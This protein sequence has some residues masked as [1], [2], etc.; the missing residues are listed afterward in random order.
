MVLEH[1]ISLANMWASF[2]L[3]LM[4]YGG[5]GDELELKGVELKFQAFHESF[6]F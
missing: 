5:L 4:C 2:P 3:N 6:T 1:R